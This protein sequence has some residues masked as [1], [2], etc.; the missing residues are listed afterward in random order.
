[1]RILTKCGDDK[2]KLLIKMALIVTNS[3]KRKIEMNK[4]KITQ[5][6]WN[7]S[8]YNNTNNGNNQITPKYELILP[9][10][11]IGSCEMIEKNIAAR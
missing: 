3:I 5:L 11:K 1:M 8:L 4:L 10:T 9:S 7:C 6:I 2:Y